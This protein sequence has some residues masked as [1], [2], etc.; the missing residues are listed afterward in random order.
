MAVINVGA[1]TDTTNTP[2]MPSRTF[3]ITPSDTDTFSLGALVLVTVGG[4][5]R[6]IPLNGDGVTTYDYPVGDG[7]VVP[8]RLKAVYATGTT[9]TGLLGLLP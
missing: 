2:T 8:C 9:A 6:G 4:I 1:A 5:V 7:G 3:T